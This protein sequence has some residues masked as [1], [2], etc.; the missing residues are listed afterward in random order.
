MPKLHRN[1]RKDDGATAPTFIGTAAQL[2]VAVGKGL[3]AEEGM[4]WY[5]TAN[6]GTRTHDGTI[7][8]GIVATNLGGG[9]AASNTRY[10]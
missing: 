7:W 4:V 1:A 6:N 2:A 10:Q 8:G 3:V 5:D 9:A